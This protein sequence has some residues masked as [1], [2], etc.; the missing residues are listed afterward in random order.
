MTDNKKWKNHSDEEILEYIIKLG[1]E[2]AWKEHLTMDNK[3]IKNYNLKPKEPTS[4]QM[5]KAEG[6]P[7]S[8]IYVERFGSWS[9]A[10]YLAGFDDEW[11]YS[12]DE[13]IDMLTE[14]TGFSRDYVASLFRGFET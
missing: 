7:P 13:Y 1:E 14:Q 6:Y 12:T 2:L 8:R 4:R 9:I 5:D 11:K 10:K 3:E